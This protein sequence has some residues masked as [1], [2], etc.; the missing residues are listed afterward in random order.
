[1]QPSPEFILKGA[2]ESADFWA[3]K[4]QRKKNMDHND[5]YKLFQVA[6]RSLQDFVMENYAMG[7]TF[8]FHGENQWNLLL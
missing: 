2:I 6:V 5:W 4:F 8:N 3:L 7:L 1:M